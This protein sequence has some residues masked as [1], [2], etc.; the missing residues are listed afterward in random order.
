MN[1][2]EEWL[3]WNL[4]TEIFLLFQ[5]ELFFLLAGVFEVKAQHT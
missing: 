1:F 4:V 5:R 3:L 2:E